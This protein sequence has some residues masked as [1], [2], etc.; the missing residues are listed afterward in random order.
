[1]SQFYLSHP[2]NIKTSPLVGS[3]ADS[4]QRTWTKLDGF[5][6]SKAN[7]GVK[8]TRNRVTSVTQ[9][10]LGSFVG[11]TSGTIS[12][13]LVFNNSLNMRKTKK[14]KR[15]GKGKGPTPSVE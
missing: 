1:M 15:K 3:F 6:V 2:S 10:I 12:L 8:S 13:S 5:G 11:G 4:S 9:T 14:G 7:S